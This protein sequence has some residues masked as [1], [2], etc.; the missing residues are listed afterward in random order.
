MPIVIAVDID[1][2]ITDSPLHW[3][4][5]N[6]LGRATWGFLRTTGL[7]EGIMRRA[8]PIPEA[9]EWLQRVAA[10]GIGIRYV[11]ARE[12]RYRKPTKVWL[13]SCA[14]PYPLEAVDLLS[15]VMEAY[16]EASAPAPAPGAAAAA[17]L[18]LRPPGVSVVEHKARSVL[19]CSLLLEDQLEIA[20]AVDRRL[21][22]REVS[23][24]VRPL[25]VHI[26]SWQ[27]Q[28]RLLDRLVAFPA[29]VETVKLA[30][31]HD[32]ECYKRSECEPCPHYRENGKGGD[33]VSPYEAARKAALA[34]AE[35]RT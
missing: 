10:Q 21:V 33:C 7:A 8:K 5:M 29:L 2:T 19:G 34:L 11:T 27:L 1:G 22:E 26:T 4:G 18:W 32:R 6:T 15:G 30:P 24:I 25:I 13:D 23:P 12:V 35:E 20:E 16:G 14:F 31:E 17:S 9:V 28:A 3:G